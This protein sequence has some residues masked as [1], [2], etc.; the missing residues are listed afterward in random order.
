MPDITGITIDPRILLDCVDEWRMRNFEGAP[1][2]PYEVV[3]RNSA[4]QEVVIMANYTQ[5]LRDEP[6]RLAD[7]LGVPTLGDM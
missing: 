7:S 5:F 4:Q 3:L 1:P 2:N 6:K